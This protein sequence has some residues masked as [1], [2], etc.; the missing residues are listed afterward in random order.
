MCGVFVEGPHE[1]IFRTSNG[2]LFY[3]RCG[4]SNVPLLYCDVLKFLKDSVEGIGM[5]PSDVGLHSVRRSGAAYLHC[6]GIPSIDI[7]CVWD[8]RS[9]AVLSYLITP[10]N[11]K[12]DLELK[13]AATLLLI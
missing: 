2:V 11:R 4:H 12:L 3:K 10:L 5:D 6:I 8:W 13:V 9:L 7:Q 1:E